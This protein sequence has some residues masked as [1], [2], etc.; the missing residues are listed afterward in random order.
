MDAGSHELL[1]VNV[2]AFRNRRRKHL[3][4]YVAGMKMATKFFARAV[5][6]RHESPADQAR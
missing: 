4:P 2:V 6:A 5:S 1:V 3:T